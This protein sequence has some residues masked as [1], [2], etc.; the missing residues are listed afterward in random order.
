MFQP[1]LPAAGLVGWRFL[2]KT[3]DQQSHL[4]ASSSQN[5]RDID[6]FRDNIGSVKSAE[7]LVSNRRMLRVVLGSFGLQDDINNIAFIQRVLEQ[8]VEDPKSL[9]N[10][11]SDSRYQDLAREYQYL[12]SGFSQKNLDLVVEN[13]ILGFKDREF[14][15]AVGQQNE[16]LRLALN[17]QRELKEIVSQNTSEETKIYLILGR[18]PLR[19]VVETALGLPAE[20]SQIDLDQQAQ[21]LGDRI[22][23]LDNIAS[24]SDLGDEGNLSKFIDTFVIRDAIKNSDQNVNSGAIALSLLQWNN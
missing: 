16:S 4:L 6:Y 5:Q 22:E 9:A 8:G 13:T 19:K 3:A 10:R 12:N 18:P 1:V 15:I 7:E 17:A 14:E 23:Q 11:L 20:F 2:E 24:L 21:I